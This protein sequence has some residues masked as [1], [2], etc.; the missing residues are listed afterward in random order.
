MAPI[1]PS[2]PIIMTS[3]TTTITLIPLSTLIFGPSTVYF[4]NDT[5]AYTTVDIN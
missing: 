4:N 2:T 5:Y 3:P 1:V